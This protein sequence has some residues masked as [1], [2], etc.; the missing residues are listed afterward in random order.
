MAPLGFTLNANRGI[1]LGAPGGTLD[2]ISGTT[3]TYNGIVAG[4]GFLGPKNNAGTL[5]LG[6]VN[7]YSGATIIDA[8]IL[9]ISADANLAQPRVRLPRA[10]WY[11]AAARW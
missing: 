1:I 11:S 9:S 10:H 2:P 5:V 6:G 3:L 8:G 4:T 7:T